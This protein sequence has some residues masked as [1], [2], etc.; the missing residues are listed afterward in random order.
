MYGGCVLS[1]DDEYY[2]DEDD[3]PVDLDLPD[4]NAPSGL[5]SSG[6]ASAGQQGRITPAG[7]KPTPQQPVPVVRCTATIRHGD[8]KGER[9]TKW[10]I[11]GSTVCLSH[12]GNLPNVKEAANKHI[13]AARLRLLGDVDLAIDTVFD[14]MENSASDTTRLA[15]AKEVLDRSGL[16]GPADFTVEVEHK[17]S[18]ADAIRDR[19]A[20]IAKRI[21]AD[22]SKEVIQGET[23]EDEES[24]D[25]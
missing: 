23:V 9:C 3:L 16:K 8:R 20:N 24:A 1:G 15:A 12:G 14:I 25:E 11:R 6:K 7:W 22:E 19:L 17:I 13:E 5:T 21:K 2:Y 18:P 10:S 4:D